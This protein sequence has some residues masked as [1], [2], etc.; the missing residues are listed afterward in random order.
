MV[1]TRPFGTKLPELP[2]EIFNEIMRLVLDE[3]RT[4]VIIPPRHLAV[5][6]NPHDIIIQ[7]NFISSRCALLR[8]NKASR[9]TY[10]PMLVAKVPNLD[11][12]QI[13]VHVEDF[14]IRPFYAVFEKIKQQVGPAAA[15]DFPYEFHLTFTDDFLRDPTKEPLINFIHTWAPQSAEQFVRFTRITYAVQPIPT[16]D[17]DKLQH[18]LNDVFFER[19]EYLDPEFKHL[20][21]VFRGLYET[22]EILNPDN[23]EK[24]FIG[25]WIKGKFI[26]KEAHEWTEE[27]LKAAEL[28]EDERGSEQ[29]EYGVEKEEED[30]EED[31]E[32]NG[33]EDNGW[34]RGNRLRSR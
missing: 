20:L 4:A 3:D 22:K 5:V 25:N 10:W 27:E 30:G 14:D 16:I 31:G 19:I 23:R 6:Q 29:M 18:L 26:V 11:V 12:D 21:E 1:V 32:E 24:N 13:I 7:K 2:P 9:E 8:T 34:K 17:V 15:Q 33:E 28:E